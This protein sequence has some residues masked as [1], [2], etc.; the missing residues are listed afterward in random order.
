MV[1]QA[2]ISEFASIAD[3]EIVSKFFKRTMKRLLNVTLAAGKAEHSRN[4]A[5]QVDD[6]SDESSASVMRLFIFPLYCSMWFTLW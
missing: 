2:T 5:M 3:K 6:S 1:L 4:S